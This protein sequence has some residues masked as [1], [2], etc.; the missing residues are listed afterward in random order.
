MIDDERRVVFA[1]RA[2]TALW[3]LAAEGE[4]PNRLADALLVGIDQALHD[5]RRVTVSAP[6]TPGTGRMR[7]IS[8][9]ITPPGTGDAAG[10]P[11]LLTA[12]D[13]A[14]PASA[15]DEEF[16]RLATL[17]QLL[18]SIVHELNNQLSIILTNAQIARRRPGADTT[19]AR[20]DKV[21]E[22]ARHSARIIRNLLDLSRSRALIRR[23]VEP[24]AV[25]QRAAELAGPELRRAQV[26]LEVAVDDALPP[27]DGDPDAL[28]QVVLNLLTNAR[29]AV[30]EACP[31]LRVAVSATTEGAWVVLRVADSGPGIPPDVAARIFEPFFS[32]KAAG[33]GTG[34]GLSLCH[35]I[36]TQHGG[37][38]AVAAASPRGAVFTIRLP[39]AR[40]IEANAG[41]A[42]SGGVR[43]PG[44]RGRMLV[45]TADAEMAD[46]LSG[47][48]TGAGHAVTLAGDLEAALAAVE[49]GPDVILAEV[50][51]GDTAG[52]DLFRRLDGD[53]H[54]AARRLVFITGDLASPELEQFLV[55]AGRPA[56][57]KPFDGDRLLAL[58][59]AMLVA[60][61]GPR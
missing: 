61:P 26:V 8:V 11:V 57:A 46:Y 25:V 13:P 55:V 49:A 56:I 15:R 24:A 10:T 22:S 45:V 27:V 37:T 31:P 47:L 7:T 9:E 39:A 43:E 38:L 59:R 60:P 36:V 53:D 51:A 41:D 14:A 34:L 2:W 3:G 17:A 20:L 44:A 52:L 29:D 28:T 35:S 6:A 16:G 58:L 21:I 23:S 50:H 5:G 48:L 54:P 30:V 42:D 32:T 18:A 12:N 1:T 19:P 4:A 33:K 40:R